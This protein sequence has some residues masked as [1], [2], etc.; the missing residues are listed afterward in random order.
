MIFLWRRPAF[1]F[2]TTVQ[3]CNSVRS[4]YSGK[5]ANAWHDEYYG[6]F[7]SASNTPHIVWKRQATLAGLVGGEGG[8]FPLLS[9]PGTPSVI[10]MGRCCQTVTKQMTVSG[11]NR[12]AFVS[13]AECYDL[14]TGQIYY[15]IPT[16]DGGITPTW[17][18]YWEPNVAGATASVP[19]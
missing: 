8:Q 10:Y 13:V 11:T 5:D 18:G 6:P 3:H 16:A 12:Q 7:V 17:I 4:A 9:S 1:F 14:R 2:F 19:G 15:D